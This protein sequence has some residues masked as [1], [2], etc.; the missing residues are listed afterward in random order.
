M[1]YQVVKLISHQWFSRHLAFWG[2]YILMTVGIYYVQEPNLSMHLAY[3]L[4]SLP[5]KVLTVYSLLYVIY[6]RWIKLKQYVKAF[7]TSISLLAIAVLLLRLSTF[8]LVYPYFFPQAFAESSLISVKLISPFLDLLI[9]SFSALALKLL[10]ERERIEQHQLALEKHQA[11][12][13]LQL[14]KSQLHPHFLFNTLNSL[15]AYTLEDP[16]KASN[17]V[18][19]LSEMLRFIIYNSHKD[20]VSVAQEVK[21]IENYINLERMRYSERLKLE[22]KVST[23]DTDQ[24]YIAPLVLLPFVENSFKHGGSS[25]GEVKIK[26]LIRIG[27]NRLDLLLENTYD[28]D[29]CNSLVEYGGIGL[30]NVQKRLDHIYGDQYHLSILQKPHFCVKLRV[31]L[32]Q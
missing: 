13:E 20:T 7:C 15:Y 11:E 3:E 32:K 19:R 23:I 14:L 25:E 18:I 22:F 2:C 31:P 4:A 30:K 8:Y 9:V 10:R 6:P 16:P 1:F 28:P 17:M 24:L 29:R 27:E 26:C 12:H 5:A 21:C